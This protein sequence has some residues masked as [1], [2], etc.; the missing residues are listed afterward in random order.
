MRNLLTALTI[1]LVPG[2]LLRR[3]ALRALGH[4]IGD[5]AT[6]GLIIFWNGRIELGAR[7]RIRSLC[8]LNGVNVRLG[9]R[10]VIG[11]FNVFRGAFDVV[12]EGGTRIGRLC[13][14]TNGGMAMIPERSRF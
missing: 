5:A 10:A 4:S 8:Y 6:V 12:L 9:E 7:S 11:S 2:G 13:H 1:L 14:F 3:A